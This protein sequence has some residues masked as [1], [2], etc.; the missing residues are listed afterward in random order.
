MSSTGLQP[1]NQ[2]EWLLGIEKILE[3]SV[4]VHERV[5][6][7]ENGEGSKLSI[8]QKGSRLAVKLH[9]EGVISPQKNAGQNGGQ[10]LSACEAGKLLSLR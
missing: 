6:R 8:P 5:H 3:E 2:Q 4:E 7:A 10:K 1:P 9:C